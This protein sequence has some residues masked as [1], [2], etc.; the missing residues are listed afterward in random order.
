[1][2]AVP[3]FP[4]PI[5]LNARV[6]EMFQNCH[7]LDSPQPRSEH[8]DGF[9][10]LGGQAMRAL[11]IFALLSIILLCVSASLG[12]LAA[13]YVNTSLFKDAVYI[14][15]IPDGNADYQPNVTWT[16]VIDKATNTVAW[17]GEADTD[18]GR[19]V[20][21][22]NP[23]AISMKWTNDADQD[24]EFWI[25]RLEGT[26]RMDLPDVKGDHLLFGRCRE[27]QPAF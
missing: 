19:T 27:T 7:R 22:V 11:K 9:A 17:N 1:M 12:I 15:C 18:R 3:A 2:E 21:Y 14:S 16:L 8:L 10:M 25:N 26:F 4:D 13:V 5:P 24:V 6:M 20:E 23:S